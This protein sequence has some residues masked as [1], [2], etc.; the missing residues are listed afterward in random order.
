VL[1][2]FL[3]LSELNVEY[4]APEQLMTLWK[5]VRIPSRNNNFKNNIY[6]NT[7]QAHWTSAH[8]NHI[9]DYC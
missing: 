2:S 7:S 3:K 8:H 1:L 9:V 6:Y 5:S 4:Y